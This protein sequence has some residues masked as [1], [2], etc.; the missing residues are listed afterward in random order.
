MLYSPEIRTETLKIIE[1]L[2]LEAVSRVREFVESILPSTEVMTLAKLREK[3]AEIMALGEEYGITN[4][5]VF[6][7]VV[8][9]KAKPGSDIDFLVDMDEKGNLFDLAGFIDDMERLLGYKVDVAIRKSLHPHVRERALKE[10]V[11][12]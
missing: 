12:I 3:R 4:I 11:K 2:P 7:S 1:S 8:T 10:A 5:E 6:G 9:G